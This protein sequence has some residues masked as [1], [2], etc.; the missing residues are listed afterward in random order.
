M[1]L[2]LPGFILKQQEMWNTDDLLRNGN[3]PHVQ[4]SHMHTFLKCAVEKHAIYME[5]AS[6]YVFLIEIYSYITKGKSHKKTLAV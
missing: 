3:Y 1:M 5:N 2:L 6:G 4:H